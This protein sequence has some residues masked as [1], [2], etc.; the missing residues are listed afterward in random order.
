MKL[1]K[2]AAAVAVYVPAKR[3]GG[4]VYI[5]GQLPF[6]DGVL[7]AKGRVPEQVSVADAAAAARQCAVNL[8]AALRAEVGE[9]SRVK[10]VAR[11]GV[12]VACGEGFTEHPKVA[13]GASE[14]LMVAFGEAGR[15]ARAAVGAP[16]LPLG[17]CVEVEAVFEVE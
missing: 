6:V 3:A 9:L 15:H 1:G 4:L 14:L 17:A 2:P 16:S 12:F 10:G 11:V 13:N 7:S 5:S 8:L